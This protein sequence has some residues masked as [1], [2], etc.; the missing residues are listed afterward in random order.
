M[1]D[2]PH[3]QTLAGSSPAAEG[4]GAANGGPEFAAARHAIRRAICVLGVGAL[5]LTLASCSSDS[6]RAAP[7]T[8]G[9]LNL[10]SARK[11]AVSLTVFFRQR[12][13]KA[14]MARTVGQLDDVLTRGPVGDQPTSGPALYEEHKVVIGW[15]SVEAGG[16]SEARI[17]SAL[18][19][20]P[21]VERIEVSGG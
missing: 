4:G 8:G 13:D 2:V 7:E 10:D 3:R 17:R 19:G 16:R 9:F 5:A 11:P 20:S 12:A 15:A 1:G 14:D 21:I 18:E 6:G